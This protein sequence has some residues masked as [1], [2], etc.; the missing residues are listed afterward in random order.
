MRSENV[1]CCYAAEAYAYWNGIK[2]VAHGADPYTDELTRQNDRFYF[3]SNFDPRSFEP[4]RF[5]YP[6]SATVPLLPLGWLDFPA[7]SKILLVLFG[8][9]LCLWIGWLRGRWDDRTL[10]YTVLAFSSYP[11]L[12]DWISL[13]PTVFFL[14]LAV[15][16]L[17]LFRSGYEITA[18]AVLVLSL[19][20]PHVA[21]PIALSILIA[22]L[23]EWRLHKRFLAWV[24]FFAVAMGLLSTLIRP[25]WIW[26]WLEVARD[27]A[28]YSPH[29][30]VDSWFGSAG[31]AVSVVLLLG[32]ATL[33][34]VRR[35]SDLLLQAAIST[36]FLFV[37]MPYRTY[38]A[39]CLVV[40]L[41]WVADN[42]EAIKA[43]GAIYQ[44]ALAAVQLAVV[45]FWL[46]TAAGAV[47]LPRGG[48]YWK[49]NF[50]L[51]VAGVRIVL[52]ALLAMM[53]A[54]CFRKVQVGEASSPFAG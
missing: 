48:P 10:F 27:Y 45:A 25:G 21:L 53:T 3:G 39:A 47:L 2:A 31:G 12:Y 44:L 24:A 46:L 9:P 51:P 37:V 13:Q 30:M 5:A 35:D 14:A 32:V 36:V 38:N 20:K 41:V 29:S 26:R 33:L 15:G 8:V 54:L 50:M 6:V 11:V 34:W 16:G 7:A 1:K 23:A 22:A 28:D 18:A 43:S 19:G 40:P 17:G 4:E 52:F 49:I 42:V